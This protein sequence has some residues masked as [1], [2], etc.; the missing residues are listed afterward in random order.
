MV[1]FILN[2]ETPYN[3]QLKATAL[4]VVAFDRLFEFVVKV[5]YSLNVVNR[6]NL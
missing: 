1:D 4:N 2:N 6:I 5:N 3:T